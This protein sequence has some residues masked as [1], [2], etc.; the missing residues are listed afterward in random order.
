MRAWLFFCYTPSLSSLRRNARARA[1]ARA[2]SSSTSSSSEEDAAQIRG[3]RDDVA[4]GAELLGAQGREPTALAVD[5]PA[6]DAEEGRLVVQVA[7]VALLTF[8][9][10]NCRRRGRNEDLH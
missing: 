10:R 6:G 4:L 8:V 9:A 5:V 2:E 7:H 3:R 1:Y